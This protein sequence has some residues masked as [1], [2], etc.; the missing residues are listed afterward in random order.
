MPGLLRSL[1][2]V[3][4][5]AAQGLRANRYAHRKVA[6]KEKTGCALAPD[7]GCGQASY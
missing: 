7:D 6:S 2:I 3:R 4:V 1:Y 5:I